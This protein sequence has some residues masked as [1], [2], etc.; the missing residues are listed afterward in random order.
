[1]RTISE[2]EML[3]RVGVE[4]P[5]ELKLAT[6]EF[7][8]GW[9]F[10]R[11]VRAEKMEKKIHASGWNFIKIGDGSLRSGV[12]D[13]SQEA[14]A[15][16]LTLALRAVSQQLNAAEVDHIELT[17]YP[18]FF[19]ARVRVFPYRIQQEAIPATFDAQFALPAIGRRRGP[20]Q[21]GEPFP[22]FGCSMP[23]LKQLLIS[24]QGPEA[25]L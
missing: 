24:S 3:L 9:E 14:T 23:Q 19:L 15:R 12:G 10:V 22:H 17:R 13:T 18:W 6:H 5:G 25:R 16:A 4:L 1:M 11:A 21:F 7:G 20:T 8:E 2:Q